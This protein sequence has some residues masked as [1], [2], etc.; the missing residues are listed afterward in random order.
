M[1]G[2]YEHIATQAAE[3][4]SYIRP[5]IMAIDPGKMEEFRNPRFWRSGSF[6]STGCS[7]IGRTRSAAARSNCW[8]CRDR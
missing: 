7:A 4:S 3:A 1:K 8:P 6:S 2:R 5:E